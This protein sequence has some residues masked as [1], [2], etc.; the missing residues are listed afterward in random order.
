M[1]GQDVLGVLAAL[2]TAHIDAWLDGGWGVDA[3]LGSQ[4]RPHDDVDVVVRVSDVPKLIDRLGALGF[5]GDK[6]EPPNTFVLA[7]D[8]GRKVDVHAVRFDM[9]GDGIYWMQNG[10]DW[11]F[12]AD[13]FKGTGT[14]HGRAV[15]CL[16]PEVQVL[17][18]GE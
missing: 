17:C 2:E 3:L 14:I 8:K 6:G 16:T 4:S 11:T 12:P 15:R 1:E 13:G 10:E 5:K 7:D 18:H 9:R